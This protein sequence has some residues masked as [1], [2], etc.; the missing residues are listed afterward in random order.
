[1]TKAVLEAESEGEARRTAA[2]VPSPAL[3]V[4][5]SLHASLMARL[6]RL[7]PAKEVAQVGAVIGRE[8]SHALLT[9]VVRKAEGEL[10]AA[11]DRLIASGLLFRQGTPPHATYLFKHALVQ[12]AAYGTLLREPRR[13]LHARIAEPLERQFAEIAES[14]PELLAR[15]YTEAGVIEKAAALWGKAG[16]RSLERSALVEAVKQLTHALD[17]IASLP[18]TPALRRE[19]IKLQ[20]ALAN[21]LMHTKGYAADE[22]KGAVEQAR[23]FIE[24][25]EA[26]GEAPEDPLVLFSVLYGVW[27]ANLLAFNA[28]VVLDL[29]AHFLTLA[30]KQ[31]AT[32]LLMIGHRI[33]GH[34]L[35]HGGDFVKARTHYDKGIALYDPAA[36][37]SLATR[38]GQDT[39]VGILSFRSWALWLLGYPESALADVEHALKDAREIG[40]AGTLMFALGVTSLTLILS[41]NYANATARAKEL[42]ALSEEKGG[43]Y[44]KALGMMQQGYVMA[45]TGKAADAV[46]MITSG[47][48][49]FRSTGATAY[50][51]SNLSNLACAYAE[52]A[53]FDAAWRCVGEAMTTV[54]ATKETLFEADIHR[55]AGEIAL[56]MPEPNVVKAEEYFD[57][58]LA[59]ARKQQA[60]SWEL[61]AAM[62]MA[63]LWRDQGK[64]QQ[65]RE[66]LA[67]VYG[68]FTEGFDTLDLREAKALLDELAS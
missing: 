32:T 39:R 62:S 67:P 8:F 50:T 66:L 47:L 25:A 65:A 16:V 5:A 40:L 36:H 33:M 51:P 9:A 60:K 43:V 38:F 56:K 11:L 48:T 54:E 2:A 30:E 63:R 61:R 17:Q 1:M 31:G 68:W 22:A 27:S 35:L 44:W 55:T 18:S 57:R 20:V 4:P 41:G 12:D 23:L 3:A 14:Q 37:R 53:N 49:A 6:D 15:H 64:P 42:S 28:D 21:A 46:Q 7:G 26:L 13:A 34:S 59:V 10:V 58:A 19:Q 29:A 24:Q 45:M 52:L